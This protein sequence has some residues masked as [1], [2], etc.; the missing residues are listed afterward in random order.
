MTPT[1]LLRRNGFFEAQFTLTDSHK[2]WSI[3]DYI[4][5]ILTNSPYATGESIETPRK[6]LL[7]V[8]VFP[9]NIV[10][11]SDDTDIFAEIRTVIGATAKHWFD[12]LKIG[13]RHIVKPCRFEYQ[14]HI[15]YMP[16]IDGMVPGMFGPVKAP[17][18]KVE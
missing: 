10:F 9:L 1:L 12:C 2:T 17:S 8:V 3:G 4:E 11:S 7:K 6:G 18:V 5:V 14:K 16:N 15:W 13:Q